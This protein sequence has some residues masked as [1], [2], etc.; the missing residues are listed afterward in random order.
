MSSYRKHDFDD[1]PVNGLSLIELMVSMTIGLVLVLGATT[2]YLNSRKTADVDDSVAR[3]QE[4]ARYAMNV[5]ESDVRMA[6]YWGLN[7]DANLAT[8]KPTSSTASTDPDGVALSGT[9]HGNDCGTNYAVDIRKYIEATNDTFPTTFTGHCS[10]FNSAVASSDILT[11]RRA[12]TQKETSIDSSKLQLCTRRNTMT[13]MLGGSCD[14]VDDNTE[15]H[16]LSTNTYYIDKASD[17]SPNYPSLR[18]ISLISGPDFR[19]DEVVPGVEDMQIELGWGPGSST[20]N[21]GSSV[22]AN[23]Q[24]ASYLQPENAAITAGTGQ[25]VAVRIWLLVRAESPDKNYVD[26]NTYEYG[27]RN[28]GTTGTNLT[29]DL[30]VAT[31]AGKAYKPNDNYRRML[32]SRTFFIRNALGT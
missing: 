9:A 25:I 10:A 17:E 20:I 13:I 32:V 5:L 15:I 1:H 4:T 3:L 22:P 26:N 18:R 27:N 12:N 29:G 11:I 8:N 28:K 31:S 2:L 30:N 23:A 14:V 21:D 6:N 7:G 19:D 24:A 16:D